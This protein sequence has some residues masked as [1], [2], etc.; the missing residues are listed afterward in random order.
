MQYFSHITYYH[1]MTLLHH[2]FLPFTLL[3]VGAGAL[4][5]VD[6]TLDALEDGAADVALLPA[7]DFTLSSALF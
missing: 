2:F 1:M 6:M 3:F 4:D 5:A 7:P